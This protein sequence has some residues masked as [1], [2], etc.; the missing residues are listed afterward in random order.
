LAEYSGFARIKND[1]IIFHYKDSVPVVGN[2]A[3]IEN[4]YV[5]YIAG[6]YREHIEIKLNELK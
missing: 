6:S 4:N 1:T 2:I 3:V 5:V